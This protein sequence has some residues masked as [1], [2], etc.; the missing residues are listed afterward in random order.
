MF[1]D[2]I[3][4]TELKKML[5]TAQEES[6]NNFLAVMK[7][8]GK[9]PTQEDLKTIETACDIAELFFFSMIKQIDIYQATAAYEQTR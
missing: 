8:A 4:M 5:H 3:P 1:A 7:A 6:K 9:A 2:V